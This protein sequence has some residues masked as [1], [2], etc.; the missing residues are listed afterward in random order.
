[1][2]K[3]LIIVKERLDYIK[4]IEDLHKISTKVTE[5]L[6]E[7]LE[8]LQYAKVKNV[9]YTFINRSVKHWSALHRIASEVQKEN[10]SFR[11]G[12]I[13]DELSYRVNTIIADEIYSA[14]QEP[15]KR[16]VTEEKHYLQELLIKVD[17]IYIIP[18]HPWLMYT[19]KLKK[20]FIFKDL[21]AG[22]IYNAKK[23]IKNGFV[24]FNFFPHTSS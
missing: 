8:W 6:G 12:F 3:Q 19:G 23:E 21:I 11:Y 9:G 4:L 17:P 5:E 20:D 7:G 22:N 13:V 14:G 24:V 16:Q 15:V 1:M 2:K 10:P 18:R